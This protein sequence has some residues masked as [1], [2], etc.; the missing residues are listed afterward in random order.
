MSVRRR[1][2]WLGQQRVDTPHL[3]SI[4]SAVSNDFDE[5]IKGLIIGENKS[6]IIRGLKINMPG[7]I[8]ASANGLKLIVADS[9][10]LH[11]S[12]DES[13]TFYTIPSGVE[14]ETLNSTTNAKVSGTFTPNTD[15]YV[16]LEFVRSVDDTTTDQVNFWNP[17]SNIEFSKTVPLAV[18]LDY[19]IVI[20]TSSFASNI[21]PIAVIQTD[22]SNNVVSI[23]D[24][25]SLL[26]R[27]GTAG[28]Q[29][30]NPSYSF[31]NNENPKTVENFYTSFS[32]TSDP[33]AGGDKQISTMKDFFDALMTELKS[34][35]GTTYWYSENIGSVLRLRQDIA[36][37]AFTGKGNVV[38]GAYDFQ[39]QV[40]ILSGT[41]TDFIIKTV[42]TSSISGNITIT[43]NSVNNINTLIA[44]YN[45]ANPTNQVYL[46][47]GDGTQIPTED[48]YLTSKA[49]QI[50]WSDKISISFIGGDLKYDISANPA[51]ADISL[52]NNQ[53]AYITL[54]RGE[55][56]LPNLVFNKN[57][58]IVTSVGNVN[59]TADLRAGDFIKDASRGDEYYYEIDSVDSLSTVTLVNPF[60]E[61]S[62]DPTVGFNAEYAFGVYESNANPSSTNLRHIRIVD[63][64]AVPF[65]EDVFWLFYRQDDFGSTPKVYARVLGGQEIQQGE[66]RDVSDNTS[67]NILD[68]IGSPSESTVNPDYTNA[69]D[70][71]QTNIHLKDNENL[72][73]GLKRLEQRNDV[74]PRVRAIDLILSSLPTGASATI[75]GET[76]VNGDYVLFTNS[77]IEGLY[78]VSGV[79]SSIAFEKMYA[80]GGSQTPIN[81]DLVRVHSGT[82]YLRTIWKKVAGYWKP[83]EV[84]DATSEPTGFPNRTD[85]VIS[86]NNTTR[87]FSISPA[88]SS[89]DIF[90]K[91]RVFRFNS[92]KTSTIPNDEG[93]YFFYFDT[94]GDLSYSTTFDISLITSKIY[95]SN[96]YWSV[97]SQKAIILADERHGITMDG[98]THEYLHNRNGAVITGGG[99]IGFETSPTGGVDADAQIS[100]TDIVFRDEDIRM[101]ISH[102]ASPANPFEQI[103][104]PIAKIPV[105]Y[106]NGAS[107]NNWLKDDATNFPVKQGT[108]NIK[109]NAYVGAWTT[110]DIN[111]G[112]Y[113]SMWVF[114]TN[115]IN[116]P[117]IAILGQAQHSTLSEAQAEDTYDS[118]NFGT[119]PVQEFKV[120]YRVIFQSSSA[121]TNTPKAM[122]VDVRDLRSSPDTQFA[123][124]APNDHGLLSG[125]NDPDHAPTAV[126]TAGVVKDGGLSSADTD[127]Q[128]SLDTLNKLFG[129]LRLKP[130]PS[131]SYRVMVTGA[132]RLL[133]NGQKLIQ[134]LKNLV[135]S[136]DGAYINFSTGVI[137]SSDGITGLGV[138]FTPA[139][140]NTNEF[141]NY[142][143][144][145]I[146][147]AVNPDN[148]ITAQIIVLPASASSPTKVDAPKAAFAKG[149]QLGQ[150]TVQEDGSGGILD[151]TEA[152]ISQLGTGG[153][154]G[155]SGTGDANSFTENLKHRLVNSY[156]NFVTPIVFEIDEN[157]FTHSF[158]TGS[159]DIANGVYTFSAAAQ[160]FQSNDL[161]DIDFQSNT[162][163]SRQVE[164]H[165]EWYDSDSRDDNAI[166]QVALDGENFETITMERQN[167]SQK[168]TGSKLLSIPS[169]IIA[170]QPDYDTL[171]ILNS[172]TQQSFSAIISNGTKAAISD[173]T[174]YITKTTSLGT[175]LGSFTVSICKDDGSYAPGEVIYSKTTLCSSLSSGV[176]VLNFSG[177]RQ[178]I[179]LGIYHI[180]IETDS[181]YKASYGAG[182]NIALHATTA[183]SGDPDLGILINYNGTNWNNSNANLKFSMQGH[184]YY[185]SVKIISSA[186][187]KKLKAIGVFYDETVGSITEGIQALQK[188]TFSGN[189]NT[190]TFTLTRFLPNPDHM[191]V[192]DVKTGQ[193]Y[194]GSAFDISGYTVTFASG[195]FYAPGETVELIFDQSQGTGYDYSDQNANLLATNHLGSTDATVDK[196]VA[197]RGIYIRRPDGTLREICID[198]NDNIV[199]YSV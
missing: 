90:S 5:L 174:L 133:N 87:T 19:K 36:N 43:A 61:D 132:D 72:T 39:G 27:L 99:N 157:N 173:F 41:P 198:D 139:T 150:V 183:P 38:H 199:I 117:V 106:R 128:Q 85:S 170:E 172:T 12:S 52:S 184:I 124:V 17:T 125:L 164:L 177:L 189:L 79:G 76:L 33:F 102:A 30:P 83:I 190:T 194:R 24:R 96:I 193:V 131:D 34:L 145:I 2:N 84:A 71:L 23:T 152:D 103:L 180:K 169:G 89:F 57:G 3:K 49:G 31:W 88:S 159:F 100:L 56:I 93:I 35:K 187:G 115:N 196:S 92:A 46:Y 191:K 179:S 94:N 11:G 138:N 114:A 32:S 7:S 69:I 165:V 8:G 185:L 78:K 15:N 82:T 123:Q 73:K 60:N 81:G 10:F 127:L 97:S 122:V 147:N 121:F 130:D 166:Y 4:E 171:K 9:A 20:T 47:T 154:S 13:G 175:P 188:F 129:Q 162:D 80:F 37:T 22:V 91:G 6:Y 109:Y 77:A 126:T 158:S 44:N 146:P 86:F 55:S 149:I 45:A 178:I 143:V 53:V 153:G 118:L 74:I 104:S 65:N 119:M 148:T 155:S 195:T 67:K 58:D 28:D 192:Y 168:F 136:F 98:A 161:F 135:L 1:Q 14:E 167:L 26:Y 116:E 107:T 142:S 48:I 111:D 134:S 62:S 42:N 59:W 112:W 144:T 137:Y 108:S 151:I 75:D 186:S 160:Q 105:Y 66:S 70:L 156:Y 54:V 197:G 68:Y 21:L 141:L 29:N 40:T 18:I 163:D 176:N 50:N 140:I 51:S 181:I 101:N 110:S 16:G 64:S 95:V 25:R 113:V 63:R 182:K 120:L